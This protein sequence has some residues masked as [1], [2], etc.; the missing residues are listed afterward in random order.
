MTH[1]LIVPASQQAG[2][3]Q[4]VEQGQER[5]DHGGHVGERGGVQHAVHTHPLALT[6]NPVRHH[7]FLGA[8]RGIKLH[9]ERHDLEEEDRREQ[10]R[11]DAHQRLRC[12]EQPDHHHD[13]ADRRPDVGRGHEGA[14]Q[15]EGGVVG[16]MLDG[17]AGFVRRHAN[18][19]N[20]GGVM[21]V[22]RQG[23]AARRWIVV[24]GEQA[25]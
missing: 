8:G 18:R 20:R 15:P 9:G 5:A 23:Q 21:H 12:H 16:R 14:P 7:E 22:L 6:D 4:E 13:V 25:V 2:P 1:V 10:E 24:V 17:V 11:A 19:R 3:H